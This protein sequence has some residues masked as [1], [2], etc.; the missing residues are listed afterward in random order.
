MERCLLVFMQ[1]AKALFFSTVQQHPTTFS[2]RNTVMIE[3]LCKAIE[4]TMSLYNEICKDSYAKEIN[5]QLNLKRTSVKQMFLNKSTYEYVID[6][7]AYLSENP[8]QLAY[9]DLRLSNAEVRVRTKAKNSLDNKIAT[10]CQF[11]NDGD[12]PLKKCIN[13]LFGVRV[14]FDEEFEHDDVYN[15]VSNNYPHLRCI[16]SSKNGYKATHIYISKAN[17]NKFFPWELQVWEKKY[18]KSNIAS[19]AKYKEGY[20]NWEKKTEGG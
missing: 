19:H 4:F 18:E 13:D 3:D 2:N 10:Y 12:I 9:S 17:D 15:I 14:I 1:F 11:H 8:M 20:I 16:D 7:L 5:G 6:Y